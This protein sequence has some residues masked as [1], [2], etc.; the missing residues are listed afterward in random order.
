[1]F[2]ILRAYE[3]AK[4]EKNK[5][6]RK[7]LLYY[8]RRNLKKSFFQKF[9]DN[10]KTMELNKNLIVEFRQFYNCTD[11]TPYKGIPHIFYISSYGSIY[12][13]YGE[14]TIRFSFLENNCDI[15]IDV[16]T[17][18]DKTVVIHPEYNVFYESFWK[19]I[20]LIGIYN[21]SVQY[22]YGEKTDLFIYDKSYLDIIKRT[23][24]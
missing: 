7:V 11:L 3:T 6:L 19:E 1:M 2:E 17:V 12:I 20:I 21:Y 9:K 22:I 23:Y 13:E 10:I 24:F 15:E 8:T 4:N 14:Y 5:F 18:S 16:N